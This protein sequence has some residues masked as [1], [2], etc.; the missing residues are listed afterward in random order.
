MNSN[1]MLSAAVAPITRIARRCAKP[2]CEAEYETLVREMFAIMRTSQGFLGADILPPEEAG[3]AYQIIVR[4]ASEA[5]LQQWDAS[6][7]RAAIHQ[8]LRNVAEDEPAYRRLSGLEAWFT[9]AVVPATMHPP[10]LRMAV[11]TWLGIFPTVSLVLWFIAPLLHDVP[12]LLRTGLLTALIVVTMT[13]V[14]MPR[15]TKLMR[16]WLNSAR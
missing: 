6:P 2:G 15:L 1:Q 8:R 7:A 3:G 10:R 5:D 13:W 12:F 4:F 11:V 14:V 16:G 9:S